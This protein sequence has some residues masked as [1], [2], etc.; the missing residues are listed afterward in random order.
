MIEI[1]VSITVVSDSPPQGLLQHESVTHP[2][3][4]CRI[5]LKKLNLFCKLTA[6]KA[7]TLERVFTV[8]LIHYTNVG[9]L[10]ASFRSLKT[11]HDNH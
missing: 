8:R 2:G 6:L 11:N 10:T 3:Y 1:T 4:N 7:L 9:L 5:S